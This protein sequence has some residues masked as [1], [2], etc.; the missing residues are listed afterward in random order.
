MLETNVLRGGA[1]TALPLIG[2][3]GTL[4]D[5]VREC[6]QHRARTPHHGSVLPDSLG[7]PVLNELYSRNEEGHSAQEM[8]A[9]FKFVPRMGEYL[10]SAF[11]L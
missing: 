6:C 9:P 4:G 5:G 7:V 1:Q 3:R 10:S 8:S 2:L 11:P